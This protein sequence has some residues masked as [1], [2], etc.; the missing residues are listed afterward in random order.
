MA[1]EFPPISTAADYF[2]CLSLF[3]FSFA[4]LLQPGSPPRPVCLLQKLAD[5]LSN[6]E[7][8]KQWDSLPLI[9]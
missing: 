1:E 5:P 2:A 4:Y 6:I 3:S 9:P 8:Q 7:K